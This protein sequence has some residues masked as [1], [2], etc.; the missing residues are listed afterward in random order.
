MN[1]VKPSL[2]RRMVALILLGAGLVLLL[3][4]GFSHFAQRRRLLTHAEQTGNTLAQSVAFQI[5]SSLSRAEAVVQ[6]TALLLANQD[7]RRGVSTDVIRRTLAA[8]PALF[9]MAVALAPGVA[10]KS[11]FQIL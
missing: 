6:Q 10:T 5:E 3:V 8:N 1:L 7:L 11:D 4:L 2:A 9:G